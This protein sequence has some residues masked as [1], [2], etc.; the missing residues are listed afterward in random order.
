MNLFGLTKRCIHFIITADTRLASKRF[1]VL[2]DSQAEERL[3]CKKV[4]ME[5]VKK[6]DE[7]RNSICNWKERLLNYAGQTGNYILKIYFLMLMIIYPFYMQD[8]YREIGT[9]KYF[10]FRKISL[11]VMGI[12][13]PVVI[14]IFLCSRKAQGN[15][16][17]QTSVHCRR[18]SVTDLFAYGYL[19]I[20]LISYLL[21]D[22]RDEAFWGTEGWY[23]GLVSQLIFV[24]IYFMYSGYFRWDNDMLYAVLGS[25]GLVLLLGILNRYS[26]Y[27]IPVPV[28]APGFISTLGNI[29]WFCGYWSVF[30]PI[31]IM[32]YWNSRGGRQRFAAGVYVVICFISGMTQGS[33][34]AYLA[35]IGIFALLF[36]LSFQ[37]NQKMYRFLEICGLFALSG[38][39]ARLL[40]H[41]PGFAM[42]YEDALGNVFTDTG[43]TLYIGAV[44]LAIYILFFYLA[45]KRGYRIDCYKA[46]RISV[47]AIIAVIFLTYI[48]LVIINTCVPGGIAGLA[49]K[50]AFIFN[51]KWGSSRGITWICG[52]HAYRDMTPVQKLVGVGPDCFAKYVY[53]IPEL[54]ERIYRE[55]GDSR[56]TNAH[57]EWITML[58][59][60]GV[61]GGICYAG[62]FISAFIRFLKKAPEK[63][64]LY[65]CAAGILT[66]MIH[67]MVSFQQVLNAPFVFLFIGIGEGVLREEHVEDE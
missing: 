52:L 32:F 15:K 2:P 44:V 4:I 28:T 48:I 50:Q 30:A 18:P 55:F 11:L 54:A 67:N 62:I 40:R 24:F 26:I 43:L 17:K 58:V 10:F 33:R 61:L 45:E 25:S 14:I 47:F 53:G 65:L 8:G 22:F 29:N 5:K 64:F 49:D 59:N 39:I 13:A 41:L 42:N 21:T 38:Q 34:S 63:T 37:D 9:V 16:K 19:L 1:Y 60:H 66:Y 23:M 7:Q 31:G 56:L 20:I 57:S 27:P 35:L 51:E 6:D 3:G 36:Y 12:M 46:L